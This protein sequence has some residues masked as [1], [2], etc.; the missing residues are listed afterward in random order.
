[1]LPPV[2]CVVMEVLFSEELG[3]ILEVSHSDLERVCQ[4]YSD[5]G[6]VCHR[7]G[8]TCGFGPEAMVRS[9]P[10]RALGQKAFYLY[11]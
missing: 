4:S 8:R 10:Q 3:L 9:P 1:M 6:V 5:A 7:I 2:V 11:L